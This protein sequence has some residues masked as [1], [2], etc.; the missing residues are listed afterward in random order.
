MKIL[1][2]INIDG[3]T[4]RASESTRNEQSK[5]NA[6]V[7]FMNR[8]L[9]VPA[10]QIQLLLFRELTNSN[11]LMV[12]TGFQYRNEWYGDRPDDG[13]Y[14]NAFDNLKLYRGV[15]PTPKPRIVVQEGWQGLQM[16]FYGMLDVS[17][18]MGEQSVFISNVSWNGQAN[19]EMGLSGTIHTNNEIGGY[20]VHFESSN[21]VVSYAQEFEVDFILEGNNRYIIKLPKVKD[22][23]GLGTFELQG[24]DFYELLASARV[25]K[26]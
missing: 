5:L 26:D 1:Q 3:V 23:S 17:N 9:T 21:V 12:C 22:I 14:I 7:H 10:S 18:D 20:N 24:D 2:D 6:V 16:S 13:E 11:H 8:E 19:D 25:N 15:K 4:I